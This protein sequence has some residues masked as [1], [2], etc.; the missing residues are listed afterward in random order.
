VFTSTGN[1][2]HPLRRRKARACPAA[3]PGPDHD[4]PG[5]IL[6]AFEAVF[7]SAVATAL[8]SLGENTMSRQHRVTWLM[9]AVICAF[10]SLASAQSGTSTLQGKVVDA[11]KA[12]LPGATATLSNTA[13][14]FTRDAVSDAAGAFTFSAVPPGT[15]TLTVALT[16]FKT[17]VAD[18]VTLQVDTITE[19]NVGLEIGSLSESV[20][21]SAEAPVI[22]SSDASIGNV[23]SGNQIRQLPLEGRN[24][25]GLLSLQPGVTYVPKSDP[26]ATMDPRY[27]SVSGARADQ[28]TVTL[29]GIDVND[30]DRQ[31]AFTSV[32]RVTL[33]SVQEFRVTTSNY[34]A[35]QG[36]S[37]GA[38]VSLVT[39]AGTNDLHGSGY[40][41]N[42]NT[43]FSSNEYFLKLSQL[44]LGEPSKPPKL[45]K[46]I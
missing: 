24:V 33:D 9:A 6:E 5:F 22:N 1:Y 36:R 20:Q 38:Q 16:G 2:R 46:N 21:V 19:L 43:A 31:T 15:Y 11:Q 41:V 29:D 34:G 40:Y 23:I 10:A 4:S 8:L 13:T 3:Y 12:S 37:S 42:R 25:V 32:L 14:G 30:Q 7:R 28:S 39:R 45:D 26:G 27:G 18:K 35:D 17:S 44:K